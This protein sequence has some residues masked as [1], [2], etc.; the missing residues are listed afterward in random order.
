MT[1]VIPRKVS[2]T[3]FCICTTSAQGLFGYSVAEQ[4]TVGW[5]AVLFE[6]QL[7]L[8]TIVECSYLIFKGC[9]VY[10]RRDNGTSP[11]EFGIAL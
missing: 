6:R 4:P 2:R 10:R 8:H 1:R 3:L 9:K 5:L 7:V 11:A